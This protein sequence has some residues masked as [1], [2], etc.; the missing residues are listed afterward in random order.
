[1]HGDGDVL[2][3]SSPP[4]QAER[5]GA[6]AM[7]HRIYT[8]LPLNADHMDYDPA[9]SF[10]SRTLSFYL[11][12]TSKL[13]VLAADAMFAHAPAASAPAI[14]NAHVLGKWEWSGVEAGLALTCLS[15][16]P[17][18]YILST[19]LTAT[20]AR[21]STWLSRASASVLSSPTISWLFLSSRDASTLPLPCPFGAVGDNIDDF[22]V[23]SPPAS[24]CLQQLVLPSQQL[25]LPAHRSPSTSQ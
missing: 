13:E 25:L 23:G 6:I 5:R 22:G 7:G 1:M 4:S 12:P 19:S 15:D 8:R 9:L 18:V 16:A 11:T 14:A 21:V 20:R 2:S 17:R 3:T 10:P 24:H